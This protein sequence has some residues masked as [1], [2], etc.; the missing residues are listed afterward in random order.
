MKKLLSVVLCFVLM[1]SCAVTVLAHEGHDHDQSVTVSTASLPIDLDQD[2]DGIPDY[3]D[4]FVDLDGDGVDDHT[5]TYQQPPSESKLKKN[6]DFPW[7]A[8]ICAALFIGLFAATIILK[9]ISKK[10]KEDDHV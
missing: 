1:T 7:F 6:S 8:V 3:L 4:S 5:P 9:N 10:K 2:Q